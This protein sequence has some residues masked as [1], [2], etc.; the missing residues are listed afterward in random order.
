[1]IILVF[2]TETTGLPLTQTISNE[3]LSLWPHIVQLSYI[4]YDTNRH[5][6][7]KQHDY[8]LK[9]PDD[10]VMQDVVVNIHGITN[11]MSQASNVTFASVV[12]TFYEDL[13]LAHTIVAHNFTFDYNMLKVELMRT[14]EL[15]KEKEKEKERERE[16]QHG[17]VEKR[18][19]NRLMGLPPDHMA[20][21]TMCEEIHT[22][23]NKIPSFCTMMK[24]IKICNIHSKTKTGRDFLKFPKL[25]ELHF[26]LFQTIPQ[27]LH[28]SL[29]DTLVC[30]RCYIK[31]VLDQDV[32][33]YNEFLEKQFMNLLSL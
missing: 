4:L 26:K 6:V 20:L 30:L 5:E 10:I 16:R 21:S 31:L 2:D 23:L 19:S 28:N 8:I 13:L 27:N 25:N 17:Q 3:M 22:L 1:M 14:V 24:S 29:N 12:K 18:R 11:E 33:D 32:L 15:E 9:I 7:V